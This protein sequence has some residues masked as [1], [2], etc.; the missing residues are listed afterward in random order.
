MYYFISI[1]HFNVKSWGFTE[2]NLMDALL[3]LTGWGNFINVIIE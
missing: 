1:G 2:V 3:L